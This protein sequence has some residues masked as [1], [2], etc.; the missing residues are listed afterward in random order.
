MAGDQ[1]TAKLDT[2][3]DGE[4]PAEEMRALD[5][6]V[7]SCSACAAEVLNRVQLKRAVQAAGKRF[8]PSAALRARIEKSVTTKKPVAFSWGWLTTATAVVL[9][10]IAAALVYQGRQGL[11]REQVFGELADLHVATLASGTPVDVVSSD[12][13]T[14]KPWFQGKIPFTFNLPELKDSEFVLV[15]GRVSYLKQTPGAEL[16]YRIRQH[17]ISVFIFQDRAFGGGLSATSPV[18]K[19]MSFNVET[20]AQDGLRYFVVGD[21]SGQD[22]DNLSRLLKDAARS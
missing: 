16:I 13:H 5:A 1:W 22:I 3:L 4:L 6:H 14:V 15:G 8:A 17:Q 10:V 19:R 18:I 11:R 20:W 12:R 21:A 7:R 2:Y 9:I